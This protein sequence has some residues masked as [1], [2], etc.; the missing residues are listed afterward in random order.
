MN[1]GKVGRA[2]KFRVRLSGLDM[3]ISLQFMILGCRYRELPGVCRI[4]NQTSL[5]ASPAA[6]QGS[7]G[8]SR[9]KKKSRP[10]PGLG[11]A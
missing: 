4:G 10:R 7:S 5:F 9:G 11:K 8:W 6:V 3:G 1:I 2:K